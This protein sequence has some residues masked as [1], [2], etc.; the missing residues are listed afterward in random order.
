LP[1][2]ALNRDPPNFSLPSSYDY[3]HEPPTPGP[4]CI[5]VSRPLPMLFLPPRMHSQSPHFGI[6]PIH[7]ISATSPEKPSQLL[8]GKKKSHLSVGMKNKYPCGDSD[9]P[10]GS[11][12]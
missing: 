3:R 9:R 1:R 5:L 8:P 4:S 7:Q 12:E 2:L 6:L 10:Q 11:N